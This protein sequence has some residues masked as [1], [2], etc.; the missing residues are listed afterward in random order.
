M[1][2][3]DRVRLLWPDH[4]GLAR[5]KYLPARLAHHGTNHVVTTFG[6]GYDRSIRNVAGGYLNDGLRDVHSTFDPADLRPSWEDDRT[7]VAVG[8]LT[9]DGAPYPVSARHVLQ[10]AIADWAALGYAVK[11]GLELEAYVLEPDGAGG[12]KRWAT[13]RSYVYATGRAAD[14]VGLIDDITWTAERCKFRTESINAEFDE[15]QFEFTLEYDDALRA[16]DEAFLFR[17]MAR[18]TALKHG[19]DLTFMG[20]PFSELAGNG[21]HV[22][23]SIVD[24]E[25]RNAFAGTHAADG[26]SALATGA[27][28]GLCRH[29]PAMTALC[30]PTVNAYRR[31]QPGA[32][33]GYWGN[34]GYAHRCAGNRVPEARGSGTRIE[35][36]L[37]DGAVNI[38]LAVA[39]V[40]QAARLG[41]VNGY[42][43]P[44]P[45]TGDGFQDSGTDIHS[46]ASLGAAL[47]DLRT[48]RALTDAIG[49]ECVANF[50]DNK[51]AEW[52]QYLAAVGTDVPGPDVTQWEL[53][54]YRNFH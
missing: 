14:P 36:R 20:K 4:L 1:T 22:N 42:D 48:D 10:G 13:P 9:L 43:C 53:D 18:E 50:I 54:M 12:W 31:L 46:A 49:A 15:S 32:L 5:G 27:L 51:Q 23:L 45:L 35:S 40:L 17:V 26:L 52:E 7:A 24:A 8:H 29:H 11:V 37:S 25:G 33:N 19:L 3:Y 2:E 47:D 16:A 34:W 44:R 30:A 41:I 21:V 28:A 6:L 38:H 39:T